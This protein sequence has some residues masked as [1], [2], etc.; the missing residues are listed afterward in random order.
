MELLVKGV[1]SLAFPIFVGVTFRKELNLS[2]PLVW[3]YI[4]LIV[5]LAY[6]LLLVET[7]PRSVHGNFAWSLQFGVFLV[8]VESAILFFS[9][10][11]L[12][13]AR[14]FAGLVI[15]GLHVACGLIMYAAATFF[16]GDLWR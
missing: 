13:T 2:S 10:M 11:S 3:A 16:A 1:L 8:Y 6:T 12:R 14:G 4:F 7:G 5:T 9:T 15:F